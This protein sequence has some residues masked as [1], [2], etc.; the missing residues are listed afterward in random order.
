[1]VLCATKIFAEYKRT[2]SGE[3][4][5]SGEEIILKFQE[6]FFDEIGLL[7]HACTGLWAGCGKISSYESGMGLRENIVVAAI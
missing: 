2:Q 1:M 6:K 4:A 5:G 3:S 7:D